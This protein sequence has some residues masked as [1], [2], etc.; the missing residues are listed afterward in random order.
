ME[1]KN[2]KKTMRINFRYNSKKKILTRDTRN[3]N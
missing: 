1:N 2:E 3:D